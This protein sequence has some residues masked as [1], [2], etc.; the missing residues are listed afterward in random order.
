MR[1]TAIFHVECNS[2]EINIHPMKGK[3]APDQKLMFTVGFISHVETD[4][5][6]EIIVHIRGGK[7]LRLPVR[8]CSKIPEIEIEE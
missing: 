4:F 1:S 7:A 3:I 5:Y 2:P 6:S 8:A